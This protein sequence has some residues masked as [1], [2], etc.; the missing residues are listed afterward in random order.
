[1]VVDFTSES[2]SRPVDMHRGCMSKVV[3]GSRDIV[4]RFVDDLHSMFLQ[5][6]SNC[7]EFVR[8]DGESKGV[9]SSLQAPERIALIHFVSPK[10][11]ANAFEEWEGK[12]CAT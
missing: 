10:K 6:L 7:G 12:L 5:V 11:E 8:M 4:C 3:E 1:M 2:L 9:D